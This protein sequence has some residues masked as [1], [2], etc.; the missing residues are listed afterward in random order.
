MKK[1]LVYFQLV[2]A[3]GL[4]LGGYFAVP[5]QAVSSGASGKKIAVKLCCSPGGGGLAI[6]VGNK[7]VDG[8]RT[9]I[10]NDCPDGSEECKQIAG[11]S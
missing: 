9:C 7:C 2:L 11:G 5:T 6:A 3:L 1:R 10:V 4:F 8:D